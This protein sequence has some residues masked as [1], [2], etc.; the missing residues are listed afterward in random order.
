ML[1][2]EYLTFLAKGYDPVLDRNLIALFRD[3]LRHRNIT[4]FL[5]LVT[6][7]QPP[8]N[9]EWDEIN[10]VWKK[11]CIEQGFEPTEMDR[12]KVMSRWL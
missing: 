5:E 8:T 1:D 9:A 2:T 10:L 7:D 11:M 4:R 6:K 3:S 12:E